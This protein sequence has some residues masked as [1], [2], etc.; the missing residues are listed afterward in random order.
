MEST[1]C[2]SSF[3]T[4]S[5]KL[6]SA[7]LSCGST[8]GL[9]CPGLVSDWFLLGFSQ[10]GALA[11]AWWVEEGEGLELFFPG[12]SLLGATSLAISA[13]FHDYIP[14][15]VAISSWLPA[16]RELQRYCSLPC[17]G[18]PEGG[19]NGFLPLH[20]C[21]VFLLYKKCLHYVSLLGPSR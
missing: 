14:A 7:F 6:F 19:G 1:C 13:S 10:I 21:L 8:L 17:S 20:T 18:S 4:P 9:A 3:P 12:S 5:G 15:K 11:V 16:L 2:C